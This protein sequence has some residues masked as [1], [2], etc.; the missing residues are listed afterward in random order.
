MLGAAAA[1][2]TEVE[3]SRQAPTPQEEVYA[4][5][6][7]A[8]LGL[9]LKQVEGVAHKGQLASGERLEGRGVSVRF[10]Q[11]RVTR[12]RFRRGP[13]ALGH[14]VYLTRAERTW[15]LASVRGL[16]TVLLQ[17][18]AL[19]DPKAASRALHAAWTVGGLPRPGS[20]ACDALKLAFP[21]AGDA[22]SQVA[23]ASITL[24]G[25]GKTFAHD[26]ARALLQA[27]KDKAEETEPGVEVSFPEPN[28]CV[29]SS[30]RE[31]RS[32]YS[33]VVVEEH[34][35]V[36]AVSETPDR[37]RVG[38]RFLRDVLEKLPTVKQAEGARRKRML[39]LLHAALSQ[40]AR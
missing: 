38:V 36:T 11:L 26:D 40:A 23:F 30:T 18:P 14:A 27:A 19:E 5:A 37:A 9:E 10:A 7:A 12:L 2:A 25:R 1:C 24:L 35:A 39:G 31:G 22:D 8:E 20:N 28:H 29:F 21:G 34:G 17:G 6:L 33:E 13:D 16:Q 3:I 15:S 32:A 4:H